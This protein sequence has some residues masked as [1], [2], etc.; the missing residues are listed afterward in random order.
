MLLLYIGHGRV[1]PDSAVECGIPEGVDSMSKATIEDKQAIL[2]AFDDYVECEKKH[3][4][5]FW[6]HQEL[7][8][9]L[10][11][12]DWSSTR[13]KR[14]IGSLHHSDRKVRVGRVG[15]LTLSSEPRPYR[16]TRLK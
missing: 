1:K 3:S 13:L 15:E 9:K 12:N 10:R 16:I 11:L 8:E 7:A 5:E 14:A 4:I 6:S 2:A